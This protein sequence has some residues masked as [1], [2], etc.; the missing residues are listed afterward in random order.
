MLPQIYKP[1]MFLL[2]LLVKSKATPSY[3]QRVLQF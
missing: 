3:L 1:G 2:V